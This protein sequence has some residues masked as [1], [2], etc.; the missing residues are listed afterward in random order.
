MSLPSRRD[1]SYRLH[2]Q[3]GQAVVT[4]PDSAGGRRDVLL[5]PYDSPQSREKYYRVLAEWR[6][7]GC[8]LRPPQATSAGPSVAEVLLAFVDWAEQYYRDPDGGPGRELENINLALRP[9]RKLYALSPAASFDSL[10][11]RAVRDDMIRS[12][13]SAAWSMPAYTASAAPSAGPRPSS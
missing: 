9:V 10:A 11:L 8:T 1:P 7:N 2:K 13:L 6:A 3:S 12:G 4:L 5:G